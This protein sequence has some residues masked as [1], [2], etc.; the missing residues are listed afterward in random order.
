MTDYI[1]PKLLFVIF[2]GAFGFIAFRIIQWVYLA[3]TDDP[4]GTII[5]GIILAFILFMIV[6]S[7]SSEPRV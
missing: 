2:L 7:S 4:I 3:F 5:A 1:M 6:F